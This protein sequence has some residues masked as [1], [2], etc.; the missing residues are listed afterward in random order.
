MAGQLDEACQIT[1]YLKRI[2]HGLAGGFS[3]T[4]EPKISEEKCPAIEAKDDRISSH[5]AHLSF[6]SAALAEDFK[7][8][9]GK[10]YK[11]ATVTRV[12]PDGIVVK[13]KAGISKVYFTELPKKFRSA[14]IMIPEGRAILPSKLQGHGISKATG[15]N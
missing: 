3:L 13:S 9:N 8:V 12:E 14:F 5:V 11:D 10:E 7:T 15:R 1:E 2:E 4:G 6:I